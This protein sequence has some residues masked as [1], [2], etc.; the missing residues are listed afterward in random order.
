MYLDDL[1]VVFKD[2]ESH[3]HNLDLVYS[4][5]REV[6]LKANLSKCKFL[7]ARIEFLGHV[8]DGADIHTVDSKIHAVPHFS[9]P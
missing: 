6:G 8:V 5:P 3:F 9:T 7:K 2:L 4:R 1:I